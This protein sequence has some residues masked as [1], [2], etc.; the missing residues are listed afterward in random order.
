MATVNVVLRSEDAVVS[1]VVLVTLRRTLTIAGTTRDAAGSPL[2]SVAVALV[3]TSDALLIGTATSDANGSYL[4]SVPSTT[5]YY[6]AA[7]KNY[8]IDADTGTA[9]STALTA[10]VTVREGVTANTLVGV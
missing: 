10:D 2:G 7:F 5:P 3:R 6:V 9:D 1:D 8:T 4:F